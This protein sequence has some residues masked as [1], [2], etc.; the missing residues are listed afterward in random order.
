MNRMIM[1]MAVVFLGLSC[2]QPSGDKAAETAPDAALLEGYWVNEAW[3]ALLQSTGSPRAA[4]VKAEIAGI[5]VQQDSGQWVADMNFNWHEGMRYGVKA[6]AG[7]HFAF[8]DVLGGSM[9]TMH[10]LMLNADG[11]L[12]L[13]SF[14]FVR[15]DGAATGYEKV[16]AAVLTGP[17]TLN[18][19]G[20][21]VVFSPNGQ[22]SGLAGYDRYDMVYDHVTDE[23]PHDQ[24]IL[25]KQG[26]DQPEFFAW[27]KKGNMLEI[28]VVEEQTED[29]DA[30]MYKLGAVAY[31]LTKK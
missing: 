16:M 20:G 3:W 26:S 25:Y 24:L 15:L 7:G 8:V 30:P 22:L 31:T 14:V 29:P 12:Q 21:E 17:Y 10:K 6:E 4:S 9:E 19:S 2:Q 18:N 13:D 28:I 23:I 5:T 1:L 11:K 27:V